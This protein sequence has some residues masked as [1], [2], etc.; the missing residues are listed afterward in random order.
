MRKIDRG[1]VSVDDYFPGIL[2][3]TSAQLILIWF[4]CNFINNEVMLR[5]G[6]GDSPA[7]CSIGTWKSK[8]R[9]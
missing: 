4:I 1:V 8:E 6:G 7:D 2:L 3:N 9:A 5:S